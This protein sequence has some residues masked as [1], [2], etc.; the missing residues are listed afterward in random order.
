[1]RL[2]S[3]ILSVCRTSFRAQTVCVL[4][5]INEAAHEVGPGSRAPEAHLTFHS[6]EHTGLITNFNDGSTPFILANSKDVASASFHLMNSE[7]YCNMSLQEYMLR[8]DSCSD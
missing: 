6:R 4:R 7:I 3:P 2:H 1:M 5:P 8:L